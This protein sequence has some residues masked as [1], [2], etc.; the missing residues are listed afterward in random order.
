MLVAESPIERIPFQ[1]S[2]IYKTKPIKSYTPTSSGSSSPVFNKSH[3][4]S[5]NPT[6]KQLAGYAAYGSF[7]HQS[8][9]R[10]GF[11][12]GPY[13]R[14]WQDLFDLRP[15]RLIFALT[16]VY[17]I[18]GK[19]ETPAFLMKYGDD[20]FDWIHPTMPLGSM[21]ARSVGPTQPPSTVEML[22]TCGAAS[23]CNGDAAYL[24]KFTRN[25]DVYAKEL[26]L[27]KRGENEVLDRNVLIRAVAAILDL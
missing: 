6:A 25:A 19:D 9:S 24:M 12:T 18:L 3:V 7:S 5:A 4:I 1:K 2:N 20:K 22:Y 10:N 8:L 27:E 17:E 21:Y 15:S 26:E 23:W 13:F 14:Y 16:L 11:A